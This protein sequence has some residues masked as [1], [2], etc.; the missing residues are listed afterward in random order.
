MPRAAPLFSQYM[1]IS[2]EGNTIKEEDDGRRPVSAK[3]R[4]K[5]IAVYDQFPKNVVQTFAKFSPKNIQL[6]KE[7]MNFLPQFKFF[8]LGDCFVPT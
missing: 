4:K 8:K 3:K 2:Y 5:I 1:L 6:V 7:E